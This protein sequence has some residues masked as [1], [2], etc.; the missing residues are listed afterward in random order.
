MNALT[1]V[2]TAEED[3][4]PLYEPHQKVYPQGV[5]GTFR[6]IKWIVLVVTLG[7][8]YLTPFIRWDR[9]P[10][11]PSQA[12]LVDLPG[13]RLYFFFI[14]IWPQEVYYLT[15]LLILAA[16]GALSH[17]RARRPGLV[18]LPLPA[19]GMVGSLPRHR[20]LDR[21]R[22]PRAHEERQP[23]AHGESRRPQDAEAFP[24]AD[25]RLV[26]GRRLGALFRRCADAGRATLRR[27]RRRWSPTSGSASSP[28]RP[29]RSPATC[30][31]RFASICARGRAS[32]RR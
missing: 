15:G 14:E 28:S 18:R 6:R 21:R 29:T 12:V 20:A 26:D 1:P 9:G 32:R 19:D 16:V 22:P 8:Y 17:E 10:G 4:A 2:D 13:R 11:A 5:K 7:I 3:D 23:A 25:D 30:A 31:S 24:L 27:C